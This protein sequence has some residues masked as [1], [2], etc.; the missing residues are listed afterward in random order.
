[1]PLTG[2][3]IFW[4]ACARTD[5]RGQAGP[6]PPANGHA[7]AAPGQ[8]KYLLFWESSEK[9]GELAER[10]GMKGDGK[11][12]ILG[13]GLPNPTFEIEAQLP[14]RI[15]GEFAAARRHGMAVMLHFDL[16]LS[17]KNRPVLWNWFDPG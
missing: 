7:P 11:T 17:W 16:H 4:L 3:V 8:P 6:A 14:D 10:V 1:M 12:R 13:F 5:A 9:A 15:R 2:L